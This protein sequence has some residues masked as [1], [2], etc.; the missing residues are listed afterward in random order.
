M[1]TAPRSLLFRACPLAAVALAAGTAGAGVGVLS[2]ETSIS[3]SATIQIIDSFETR[4]D[5]QG[6]SDPADLFGRAISTIL[7]PA[8]VDGRAIARAQQT[9]SIT[10][11]GSGQALGFNAILSA[12][13]LVEAGS[14]EPLPDAFGISDLDIVFEVTGEPVDLVLT[15]QAT[16]LAGDPVL[17]F[18]VLPEGATECAFFDPN[19]PTDRVVTLPPGQWTVRAAVAAQASLSDAGLLEDD[20]TL[21]VLGSFR[22]ISCRLADTT[23]TNTNPGDP[24]FGTPDGLIN[25]ADLSFYVEQWLGQESAADLTTNNT[26]PGDPGYA[27]GDGLVNGADLSFYVEQWLAGCP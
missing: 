4:S 16:V 18:C 14:T 10:F 20:G 22:P 24:G 23:T 8:G 12:V 17:D 15:V 2:R 3:Y 26:N 27:V 6:T 1:D 7:A 11:G 19:A 5:A 25:G 13:A 9:S 21:V